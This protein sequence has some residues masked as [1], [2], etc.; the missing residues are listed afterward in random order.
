M[1]Q[2]PESIVIDQKGLNATR[3]SNI[4]I[5]TGIFDRIRT[6]FAEENNVNKALFSFNS[7]GG[8]PTCKGNGV[9]FTDLAYLEGV[10]SICPDCHGQ[11]YLSEV[12]EMTYQGKNIMDVLQL[13][14]DECLEFFND[15]T[16]IKTIESLIEVG[17]AY[18][19]LGQPLDTLSGGVCQRIKLA[20]ELHKQGEIYVLDEPTTGPH[21]ADIEVLRKILN[22][23][24][25]NGSSVIVIEHNVEL[26]R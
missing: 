25:D 4:A 19:T 13:S 24:V 20:S 11:R 1:T 23:L 6:L 26:M 5:Y 3:R 10:E 17:L 15:K 14:L 7:K 16:I 8:C 12:L 9:I 18:L 22:K 21:M 2:Y